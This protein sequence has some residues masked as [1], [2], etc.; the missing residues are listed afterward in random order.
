MAL[1]LVLGDLLGIQKIKK[2]KQKE[3]PVS[4]VRLFV[5]LTLGDGWA[6]K[7]LGSSFDGPSCLAPPL[8]DGLGPT[9]DGSVANSGSSLVLAC[10]HS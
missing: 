3:N 2:K 8:E 1:A 6:Q 4:F 10:F 9:L 7:G 5:R